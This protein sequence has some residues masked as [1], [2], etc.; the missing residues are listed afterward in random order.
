M[1]YTSAVTL[2]MREGGEGA[3]EGKGGGGRANKY[4]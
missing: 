4:T 1:A 3:V 2:G